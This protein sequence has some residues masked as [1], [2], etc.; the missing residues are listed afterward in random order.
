MTVYSGRK[1][2][3]LFAALV[4]SCQSLNCSNLIYNSL[5]LNENEQNIKP[6]ATSL[7]TVWIKPM[8]SNNP[9]CYVCYAIYTKIETAKACQQRAPNHKQQICN[10]DRSNENTLPIQSP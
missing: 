5:R 7:L 1:L 2:S 8:R 6:E 3:P 9:L 4:G 10:K